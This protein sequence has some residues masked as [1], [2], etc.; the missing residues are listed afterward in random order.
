MIV[1]IKPHGI[2]EFKAED[3]FEEEAIN[4]AHDALDDFSY[5]WLI[6]AI[7]QEDRSWALY[8]LAQ[9]LVEMAR[10]WVLDDPEM[11]KE[12]TE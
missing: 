10:E 2:L 7:Q 5:E 8:L 11:N 12:W 1:Q 9:K 3:G 6:Y 4:V